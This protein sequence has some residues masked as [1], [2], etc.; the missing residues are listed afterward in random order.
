MIVGQIGETGEPAGHR[1]GRAGRCELGGNGVGNQ[2]LPVETVKEVDVIEEDEVV[3]RA[4][5]GDDDAP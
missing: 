1:H 4:A 2:Y 3:N 5:I